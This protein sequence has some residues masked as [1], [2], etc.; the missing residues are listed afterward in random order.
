MDVNDQGRRLNCGGQVEIEHE[1]LIADAG[2]GNGI[3]SSNRS[4]LADVGRREHGLRQGG[5]GR[6]QGEQRGTQG[7]RPSTFQ[8]MN[9]HR[10]L[11]LSSV[12]LLAPAEG[13]GRRLSP[14]INK[15]GRGA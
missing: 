8:S 6:N 1:F 9:W 2:L 12:V 4:A 15:P 13:S 14:I 5:A 11:P 3:D 7:R 10:E